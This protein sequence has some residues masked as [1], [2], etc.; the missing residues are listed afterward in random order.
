MSDKIK[1][2]AEKYIHLYSNGR[3]GGK[4]AELI[5]RGRQAEKSGAEVVVFVKRDGKWDGQ[6]LNE[7]ALGN[8]VVL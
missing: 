8:G 6:S 5:K 2:K 1:A 3:K 4:V 7:Y